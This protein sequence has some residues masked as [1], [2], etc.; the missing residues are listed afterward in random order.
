[1]QEPHNNFIIKALNCFYLH[2]LHTQKRSFKVILM[3]SISKR[4][5]LEYILKYFFFTVLTNLQLCYI[6]IWGIMLQKINIKLFK[7][8]L[9]KSSTPHIKYKC[10]R[11]KI[12]SLKIL[13]LYI[14]FLSTDSPAFVISFN[15]EKIKPFSIW[16]IIKL[17]NILEYAY[18]SNLLFGYVLFISFKTSKNIL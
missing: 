6:S 17:F 4:Y 2:S 9:G 8:I 5:L 16:S 12:I 18:I 13:I 1:M 15:R 11:K 7:N 14:L 10:K 3:K